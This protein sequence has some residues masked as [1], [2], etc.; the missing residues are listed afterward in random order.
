M[1]IEISSDQNSN[2]VQID[3]ETAKTANGVVQISGRPEI[4]P[5]AWIPAFAGM[6][7]QKMKASSSQH[8]EPGRT[9]GGAVFCGSRGLFNPRLFGGPVIVAQGIRA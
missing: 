4:V 7:D 2:S 3:P 6:T 9:L 8:K 5:R 1:P